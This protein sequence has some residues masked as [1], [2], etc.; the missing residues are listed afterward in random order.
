MSERLHFHAS[1]LDLRHHGGR[2][3][4]RKGGLLCHRRSEVSL[5][6][7]GDLKQASTGIKVCERE[8]GF[9]GKEKRGSA[10]I[11]TCERENSFF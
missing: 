1:P 5:I 3:F 4:A 9:D 10:G 6:L 2:G 8:K 7:I 11:R